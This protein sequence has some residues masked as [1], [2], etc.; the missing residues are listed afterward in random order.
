MMSS[1]ASRDGEF[2]VLPIDQPIGP[3]RCIFSNQQIFERARISRRLAWGSEEGSDFLPMW[4]RIVFAAKN[5]KSVTVELGVS[6]RE[7]TKRRLFMAMSF[8]AALLGLHFFIEG[9]GKG[10]VPP[11]MHYVGGGAALLVV[12]MVI[13]SK[14]YTLVHIVKMD[15]RFVWL[16][17]VGKP[18]LNSLP[19]HSCRPEVATK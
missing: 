8:L 1:R 3:D 17:G 19:V 13:F 14:A 7:Q 9:I 4:L 6:G 11:P 5:M 15:G 16:R 10:E 2:L 18:F 12:S